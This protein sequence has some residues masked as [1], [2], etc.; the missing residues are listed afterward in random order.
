MHTMRR[1]S[2]SSPKRRDRG[3]PEG[4]TYSTPAES[5]A[6]TPSPY[7]F[8]DRPDTRPTIEQIAMGLHISRT[9]HALPHRSA[10]AF[11][12]PSSRSGDSPRASSHSHLLTRPNAHTRRAS[13]SAVVLPPPPARSS[14]KK[15]STAST[16]ESSLLATSASDASISTMTTL[17]SNAPS[18]PRSVQSASATS[19]PGKLRM[20]M[21]RLLPSRKG[22]LASSV[23]SDSPSVMTQNSD[24]DS[25]TSELTP[26]KMVRFSTGPGPHD[27]PPG[28]A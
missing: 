15:S 14:L 23:R 8:H 4:V 27:V 11:H 5:C 20:E 1:M 25:V 13:M 7:N 3:Q 9:P 24:N 19:F 22:T 2:Y 6:P 18:T 10:Q 26:R 28:S 17:T 12:P 16:A 21:L